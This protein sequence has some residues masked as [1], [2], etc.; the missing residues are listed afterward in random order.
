M[1]GVILGASAFTTSAWAC[2]EVRL[3][4]ACSA[5]A[6]RTLARPAVS[7]TPLGIGSCLLAS[8]IVTPALLGVFSLRPR[9]SP[10]PSAS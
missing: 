8:L 1:E 7:S 10:V 6:A 2:S 9:G 4:E 3:A 5:D